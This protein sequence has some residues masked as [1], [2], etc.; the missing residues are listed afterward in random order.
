MKCHTTL[1]TAE[2]SNLVNSVIVVGWR[3]HYAVGVMCTLGVK[4][5]VEVGSYIIVDYRSQ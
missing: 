1:K 3:L 2:E 5:V 4:E